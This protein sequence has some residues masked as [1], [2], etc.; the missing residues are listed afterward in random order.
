[1][2]PMGLAN[3]LTFLRLLLAP[4]LTIVLLSGMPHCIAIAAALFVVAAATDIVDGRI[5]RAE[6]TA[7]RVGGHLDGLADKLLWNLLLFAFTYLGIVPFW[8]AA[9][10]FTR[11]AVAT[12]F[13]SI[14]AHKGVKMAVTSFEG[15]A[16]VL[17]Q[18]I[19]VAAGFAGMLGFDYALF[20]EQYGILL[21]QSCMVFFTA[22]LIFGL[23]N[24]Y[25]DVVRN[26]AKVM[27]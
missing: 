3:Q 11:D 15:K 25:K 27:L 24:F 5:A 19:G 21:L 4:V 1:M 23:V 26:F 12:E 17:L 14:A 2:K 16:K 6:G 18:T 8:F 7:G 9:I 13:K 20:P 22:A 10:T